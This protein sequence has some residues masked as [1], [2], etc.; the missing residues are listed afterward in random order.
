MYMN[1][2]N[3]QRGANW[4]NQPKNNWRNNYQMQGQFQNQQWSKYFSKIL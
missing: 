2:W 1:N 3:S 4:N